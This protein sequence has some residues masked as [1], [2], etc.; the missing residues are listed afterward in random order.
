MGFIKVVKYLNSHF[1]LSIGKELA[2]M[3]KAS[4]VE[5]LIQQDVSMKSETNETR[6]NDNL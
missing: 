1:I 4:A 3:E 5:Y 6:K 2:K